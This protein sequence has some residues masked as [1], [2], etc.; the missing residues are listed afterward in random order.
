MIKT[1]VKFFCSTW[2]IALFFSGLSV[3][4]AQKQIKLADNLTVKPLQQ[5]DLQFTLDDVPK[6][7]QVRLYLD[8]RIIWGNLG[9]HVSGMGMKVNNSGLPGRCLI[10]KPLQFVKRNDTLGSWGSEDGNGYVLYYSPDFSDRI[11]NDENYIYGTPGT[12][13]F[14]FVWDISSYVRPGANTV[15]ITGSKSFTLSF[16]F[17]DIGI[18]YGDPVPNANIIE[19]KIMEAPRGSL[20][21]YVP[22]DNAQLPSGVEVSSSGNIRFT[23]GRSKFATSSRTSLPDGKWSDNEAKDDDWSPVAAGKTAVVNWRGTAYAVERRITLSGDHISIADTISNTSSTLVGVIIENRLKL[24]EKPRKVYLAGTEIKYSKEKFSAAHPT[25]IA[26]F[27]EIAV[28]MAAEDDIFR[29]HCRSFANDSTNII[30]LSDTMLGVAPGKSHTL[31]WSIYMVPNGD[32]W[33]IINT[34]RRNWGSNTT[35]RGPSKWTQPSGVPLDADQIRLWLQGATTVV[36]CNPNFGKEDYD[37][38][39]YLRHGTAMLN[40]KTWCDEVSK[41][42]RFLKS[43]CP[44]VDTFVYLHSSNCDNTIS[45]QEYEACRV[46]TADGKPV[47][48]TYRP[49]ANVFLTTLENQYGKAWMELCKYIVNSLDN[50]IY[51]DEITVGS[52]SYA[53][54]PAWD[55]CTAVINPASHAVTG[56]LSHPLL[57]MQPLRTALME[58]LRSKGKRAIANGAY[59][60]RTMLNWKNLSCFMESEAYDTISV[61]THLGNPLCFAQAYGTTSLQRYQAARDLLNKASIQFI[62][63][64]D[65]APMF[66]ITPIELRPG[67]II[68]K[69]R[70]LTNRSGQFGWGDGCQADVYVFDGQGKHVEKPDVKEVRKSDKI[71]TELR[72]PGDHMAILVRK[73]SSVNSW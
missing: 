14:H 51:I 7:A 37:K 21:I 1:S 58:Y 40:C 35:L 4:A 38:K 36:F 63:F 28:G 5:A 19:Q 39:I 29:I 22:K 50:N 66:P 60:T 68:G 9:G 41:A 31:E 44:D 59:C 11:K 8:A 23:I 27:D 12:D 69:E 34:I 56:K 10:N 33:N 32:Y 61:Q 67:V 15:T 70:I 42:T 2:L 57:L 55:E 24:P 73:G 3:L 53:P 30:G 71:L 43:T 52:G 25:A 20:P 49:P 47:K 6:G 62:A 17:R 26:Q 45:N 48:S 65:E 72:M 54:Y 16:Q 18:E 64:S 46:L 13:P